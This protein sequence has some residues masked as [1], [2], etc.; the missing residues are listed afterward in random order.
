MAFDDELKFESELINILFEKGCYEEIR[1]MYQ[2]IA[3]SDV[4]LDLFKKEARCELLYFEIMGEC[5]PEK[6]EKLADKKQLEY[7][8]LTALYPSRKRL[9]YAYY[10]LYKKDEAAAQKEYE[11]LLKTAA[12]HP[13]K[14]EGAMELKEAE[15]VKKRYD[16]RRNTQEAL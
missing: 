9:M 14:A 12:T 3:N 2:R 16:E 1:E 8:R 10:L 4:V 13:V 15:R 5:N 11:A 6:V 7:I